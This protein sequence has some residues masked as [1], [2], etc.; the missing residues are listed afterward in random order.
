M[1]IGLAAVVLLALVIVQSQSNC[2]RGITPLRSTCEDVKKILN[3]DK[4]T[5]P[6][7][8][9]TVPDF[10]VM[11]QFANKSCGTAPY[12]WRVPKG[13]VTAIIISPEKAMVPADFGI[14]VTK[15][16]K[17]DDGEIVGLEH[18]TSEEEGV[19]V[20]LFNGFVQNLFLSP[21]KADEALRCKQ[22]K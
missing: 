6:I 2:W 1:K 21:R 7:S 14:D 17:R 4:C 16:K 3:V 22:G 15:Y 12:T 18:Y 20:D 19:R 5:V 10:R 8:N 11:I 13:T 9:Y